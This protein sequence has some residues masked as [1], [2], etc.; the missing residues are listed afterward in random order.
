MPKVGAGRSAV[1]FPYTPKGKKA[2]EKLAKKTGKPVKN[3]KPKGK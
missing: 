2:A 3:A 1:H